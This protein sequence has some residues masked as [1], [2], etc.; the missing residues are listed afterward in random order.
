MKLYNN[1]ET[2]ALER[3]QNKRENA[4]FLGHGLE[5]FTLTHV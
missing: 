5:C 3:T 4:V 1:A 2:G